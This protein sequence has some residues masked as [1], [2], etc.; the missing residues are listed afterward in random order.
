M[1]REIA[2]I[3]I[4][5]NIGNRF[6]NCRRAIKEI[7]KFKNTDLIQISS[8]YETEPVDIHDQDWFINAVVELQT[9]LSAPDLLSACMKTEQLLGRKRMERYGPRIIDLDLL[10]YS[11]NQIRDQDLIVPHP[12]LHERRFVL[13]PLAEI[14]P[15]V[16]H[17][18][19][20]Q[21]ALQLLSQLQEDYKVLL[22]KSSP[23]KSKG[24]VD[25]GVKRFPL[26]RH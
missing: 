21:T 23:Q 2:F 24:H 7:Q 4:G 22:V 3:G 9:E 1:K 26:H 5:S 25:H 6:F 12:R 16:K 15:A 8:F 14:A 19:L 10:L 20:G 18:L 13:T 17:P 11:Q